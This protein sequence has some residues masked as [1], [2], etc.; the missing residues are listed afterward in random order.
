MTIGFPPHVLN[1]PVTLRRGRRVVFDVAW[2][3]LLAATEVDSE[4]YHGIDHDRRRD[5]ARDE[6][7]HADGW[8]VERVSTA[9][10]GDMAGTLHRLCG[11]IAE[12]RRTL[13]S[14]YVA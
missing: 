6:A 1:Y 4:R 9:E 7:T 8:V 5:A 14:R 3:D 11:F 10:L 13:G 12:A 2:P